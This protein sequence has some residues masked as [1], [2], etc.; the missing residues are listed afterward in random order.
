MNTAIP[1]IVTLIVLGATLILFWQ[2]R[3]NRLKGG[4]QNL[5]EVLETSRQLFNLVIN[6]QQHRGMCSAW[7]SGDASFLPRIREK[8]ALIDTLFPGLQRDARREGGRHSPCFSGNEF[9]LFIFRWHSLVETLGNKQPEQS[10]AEHGQLIA[11]V[12]NWLAALG[13]ARLEPLTGGG[14]QI[15]RVCNYA[16]RLPTLAECLGQARAIGSSVAARHACSPVARVRLMFLIGRA[17]ALLE[18]AMQANDG[19]WVTVQARAAIRDLTHTVRTSMLLSDGVSVSPENYFA[20]ATKAIDSVV[21]W[22]EQSGNQLQNLAR[23]DGSPA[24]AMA[25]A[26]GRR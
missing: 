9:S 19:G 14:E 6:L 7:L 3:L 23:T 18:Q 17:E 25:V 24:L 15:G 22:I 12:L 21:A 20:V 1:S 8:Q 26:G 13:E 16:R 11:L 10:I 5:E 2:R 4:Q